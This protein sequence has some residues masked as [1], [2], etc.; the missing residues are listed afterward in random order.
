MK[1]AVDNCGKVH[2]GVGDLQF[3]CKL[4][5]VR[6]KIIRLPKK[7]SVTHP[8]TSAVSCLEN[9]RLL[10]LAHICPL[11]CSSESE[12][13]VVSAAWLAKRDTKS[14]HS[15]NGSSAKKTSHY[16]PEDPFII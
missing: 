4:S 1:T 15:L 5:V 2:A 13:D 8:R 16:I 14:C 11:P 7:K 6:K 10:L 3:C 9:Y 12:K